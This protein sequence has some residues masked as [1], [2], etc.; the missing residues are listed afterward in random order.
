MLSSSKPL[1]IAMILTALSLTAAPARQSSR[2]SATLA[3]VRIH[4]EQGATIPGNFMG[5]S[6][7]W[8][9]SMAILG[10]SK[11]GP[12]LI[13]QQLLKNLTSFGSDP[14]ELRI[15]GNSTDNNGRPSGDRMK[16]FAEL[17]STLH[18]RF[19][20]GINLR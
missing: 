20:L 11:S 15:G 2:E 4:S 13:Y 8:A 5:L 6:H 18:S 1:V 12:N 9:N 7:E 10:Y 16:P 3:V 17:A 14:I 19:I